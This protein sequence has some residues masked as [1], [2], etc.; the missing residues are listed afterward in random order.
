MLTT[1]KASTNCMG[2]RRF[3]TAGSSRI[4]VPRDEPA[5]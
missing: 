1:P 3:G 2:L 5:L 4:D